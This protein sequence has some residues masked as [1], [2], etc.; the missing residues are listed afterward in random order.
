MFILSEKN[1]EQGKKLL[2]RLLKRSFTENLLIQQLVITL[3]TAQAAQ[4][5]EWLTQIYEDQENEKFF[6]RVSVL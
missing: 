1:K 5:I 3:S 6:T 4:L 2:L